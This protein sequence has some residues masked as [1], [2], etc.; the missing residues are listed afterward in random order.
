MPQLD[1]AVLRT[2]EDQWQLGVEAHGGDV[3]GMAVQGLQARRDRGHSMRTTAG[4]KHTVAMLWAWP[5]S[6]SRFK[7]GWQNMGSS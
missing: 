5:S 7:K 2:S 3:V 6:G 1:G 4:W